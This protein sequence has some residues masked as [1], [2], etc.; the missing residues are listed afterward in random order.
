MKGN[1]REKE[2]KDIDKTKI[3]KQ[4]KHILLNLYSKP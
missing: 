3:T 4:N 2:K 1:D